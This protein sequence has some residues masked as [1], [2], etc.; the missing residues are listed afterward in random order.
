[1]GREHGLGTEVSRLLRRGVIAALTRVPV[2]LVL[3]PGAQEARPVECFQQ[4]RHHASP[5]T[6]EVR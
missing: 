3:R 6:S 1:M 4:L 2:E 5:S